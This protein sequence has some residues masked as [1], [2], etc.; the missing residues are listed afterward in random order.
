MI[1]VNQEALSKALEAYKKYFPTK[2]GDEIYKW[3]AVKCFQDN[4]NIEV[5]D[6]GEMFY[7]A[8]AKRC[9]SNTISIRFTQETC[10]R[11]LPM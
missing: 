1:T 2:I 6:F 8:T 7:A 11:S 5:I 3:K 10:T 9:N 4:W